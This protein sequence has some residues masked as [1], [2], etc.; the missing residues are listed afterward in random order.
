VWGIGADG[1]IRGMFADTGQ[2]NFY[3]TG[4][5]FAGA[6]AYSRYLALLIKAR[7]ESLVP[8]AE[9]AALEQEN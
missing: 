1:E 7:L 6:R 2:P 5:G 8:A 3:V 9:P 4:G